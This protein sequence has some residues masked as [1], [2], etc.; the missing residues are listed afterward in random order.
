MCPAYLSFEGDKAAFFRQR[1]PCGGTVPVMSAGLVTDEAFTVEAR[2]RPGVAGVRMDVGFVGE[3][4]GVKGWITTGEKPSYSLGLADG[5]TEPVVGNLDPNQVPPGSV[6]LRLAYDPAA[7]KAVFW[8]DSTRLGEIAVPPTVAR[9]KTV[10]VGLNGPTVIEYARVLRGVAPPGALVGTGPIPAAGE[11]RVE[12]ANGDRVQASEVALA[13]G[14]A[15]LATGCGEVRCSAG[16]V[17]RIV[18][19]CEAA[20]ERAPSPAQDLVEGAFGR[21]SLRLVRMTADELIGRSED[22]G[23]VRLQRE[24]LGQVKFASSHNR[25]ARQPQVYSCQSRLG[26]RQCCRDSAR[27]AN[28]P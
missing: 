2:M 24:G 25:L 15:T 11:T 18:F 1:R 26:G 21:L 5:E 9:N 8:L 17:T 14:R 27:S 3:G 13:D 22:L 4:G 12:F 28:A 20:A 23:E 6:V 16:V 7:G 19:G 10:T